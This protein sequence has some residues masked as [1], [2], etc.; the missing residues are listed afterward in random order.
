MLVVFGEGKG[1]SYVSY[2]TSC[3]LRHKMWEDWR[4]HYPVGTHRH[5]ALRQTNPAAKNGVKFNATLSL[6]IHVCVCVCAHACIIVYICL[7]V[8]AS[9]YMIR[10]DRLQGSGVLPVQCWR[11]TQEVQSTSGENTGLA[12]GRIRNA[13]SAI[14]QMGFTVTGKMRVAL[15]GLWTIMNRGYQLRPMALWDLTI[16]WIS[17]F[18]ISSRIVEQFTSRG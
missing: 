17:C 1:L 11:D 13:G 8:C 4:P 18:S 16:I 5:P 14:K 3:P 15:R 9:L 12:V 6:H 10:L 7:C 2:I